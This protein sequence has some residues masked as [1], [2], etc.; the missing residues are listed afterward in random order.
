[1][2]G[3]TYIQFQLFRK[4]MQEENKVKANPEKVRELNFKNTIPT[5]GLGTS[6]S[7][8]GALGKCL[9]FIKFWV[10][11]PVSKKLSKLYHISQ[12]KVKNKK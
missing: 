9:A 1:M 7:G 8:K 2:S 12:K 4:Q 6:S 10:Q 5:K 11:F 3:G